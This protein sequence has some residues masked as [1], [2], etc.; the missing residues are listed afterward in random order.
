MAATLYTDKDIEALREGGAILSRILGELVAM[1]KPGVTTLDLD[2]LARRRMRQAG[3]APS[4]LGYTA[5]G[6]VP[7][8]GAV[9]ASI[10]DEVVHGPPRP[11]REVK[12]GSLL[13][14]DIGLRYKGLC[15]DM[16]VTVPVGNVP[17]KARKLVRV[18]REALLAGLEEVRPGGKIRDISRAVQKR[19]EHAG[20]SVVRDLVGHGVGRGV[21][22]DPRIPNY[23]DPE[24]PRIVMKKGMVLAIEPMVN[25]GAPDVDFD[26]Q[27]GWTVRTCDGSLSAHWEVTVAVTDDG[28]EILTPLP[29]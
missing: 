2:E 14:L 28:H 12:D 27:D 9:C 16:A 25:A 11:S 19:V 17:E 24:L 15:T 20:F 1:A 3:G 6:P 4:F 8:D 26:D 13:K 5:G 21:H 23:D 29:I 10:D 18:T 22:E 7:F